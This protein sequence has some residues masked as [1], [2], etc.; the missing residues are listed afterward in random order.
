MLFLVVALADVSNVYSV[1]LLFYTLQWL[2]FF[3]ENGNYYR[4]II[5]M[6]KSTFDSAGHRDRVS[7][8]RSS[9]NFQ[10]HLFGC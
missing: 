9:E 3:K 10:K 4:K 7:A 1:F 2:L 8:S 5:R 6:I